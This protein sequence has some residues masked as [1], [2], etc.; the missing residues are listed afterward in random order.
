M[1]PQPAPSGSVMYA[2]TAASYA[3]LK[4]VV[5]GQSAGA[6]EADDSGGSS[7]LWIVIGVAVLLL[8]VV[9]FVIARR[10]PEEDRE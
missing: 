5:A 9:G 6:T 1:V 2:W 8:V 3:N 7:T 4:P 10:K